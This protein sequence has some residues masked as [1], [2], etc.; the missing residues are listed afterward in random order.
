MK[1]MTRIMVCVL[2]VSFLCLSFGGAA[3]C[4]RETVAQLAVLSGGYL[5]D[6]VTT[7]STQYWLNRLGV[8]GQGD[9]QDAGSHT[10]E[11]EP[12]HEHEH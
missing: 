10:H 12:M 6:V 8:E 9:A 7:L 1:K 4:D 5:G 11:A 3:G 2:S